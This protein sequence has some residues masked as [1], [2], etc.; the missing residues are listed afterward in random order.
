MCRRVSS[1]RARLV[2]K[3]W[4]VPVT[5]LCWHL[6]SVH[7]S[8]VLPQWQVRDPSQS[9]S[10]AGDKLL[11]T[12]TPL[13]QWSQ[14]RMICFPG[15]IWEPWPVREKRAHT[16]L[17]RECLSTHLCSV[18][19]W[20][21]ILAQKV[22]SCCELISTLKK[23][24]RLHGCIKPPLRIHTCK[25]KSPPLSK[26]F[27]YHNLFLLGAQWILRLP[28]PSPSQSGEMPTQIKV[29]SLENPEVTGSPFKAWVGQSMAMHASP[30]AMILCV[31]F[32]GHFYYRPGSFNFIFSTTSC[33]FFLFS[34]SC[35]KHR[36]LCR[37]AE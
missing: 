13:T 15:I 32:F 35:G 33:K 27:F 14:S 28:T 24:T 7:S 18:S 21:L 3:R 9:A 19:C 29:M 1:E 34:V 10:S 6:F 36:F 23:K 2:I 20:G 30:P 4:Q 31:C 37:P 5:F 26:G 16:Y 22:A 25:E 17:I 11:F 12:Y 8:S